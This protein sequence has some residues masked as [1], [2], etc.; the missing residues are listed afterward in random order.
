[1]SAVISSRLIVNPTHTSRAFTRVATVGFVL[2]GVVNTFLGPILPVLAAR[3]GL[4]DASAGYFFTAQ[5]LG[6]IL[7]ANLSSI[8][9]PSRG[10][11][12]SIGVAYFLM[13]AGVGALAVADRRFALMGALVWGIGFG[14]A[15]PST[16]LLVS[17]ANPSKRASA[18]SILNFCWGLGAVVTP[19]VIYAAE[20]RNRAFTF[21]ALLSG[22]LLLFTISLAC[23][24]EAKP[25][26]SMEESTGRLE[27]PSNWRS[28]A[29]VGGMFFLYVAIEASVGGWIATLVQRLPI[30]S[31][32][33]WVLAQS[34]FWG[35]LLC[36]RGIAPLAL[37]RVRERRVAIIGL[38]VA[39]SGICVLVV[40]SRWQWITAAGFVVG[41]GLAAVFPITIALLSR[42]QDTEKR[43][44]GPMFALAGLGG[45]TMPWL[46]GA[47]STWS[48]SLHA[49]LMV[50][51]LGTGALVWLHV[52]GNQGSHP[53]QE[54]QSR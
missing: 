31:G 1:M 41:L 35:G 10:F 50:P 22:T 19:A 45:A 33:S 5:F 14:L 16:N 4:S 8:L 11:R 28:V 15:I 54:P 51:L 37:M 26:P 43:R 25:T 40:S 7:G 48:G 30:R 52:I 17:N 3:W 34:L 24:S 53:M 9:L 23:P 6:S 27:K 44:A 13:T 42:F 49:G 46:V 47:V 18:L 21:V 29:I 38:M 20:R 2:T 32:G 12:F 39:G 36:G